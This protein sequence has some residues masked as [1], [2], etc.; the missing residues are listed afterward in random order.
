MSNSIFLNIKKLA[1]E[2]N[3]SF[4]KIEKECGLGNGTIANIENGNPTIST[5]EKISRFFGCSVSD[6]LKEGE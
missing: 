4:S 3:I 1:S 6:L 5:I 2:Q